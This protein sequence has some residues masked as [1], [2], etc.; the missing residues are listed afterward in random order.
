MV[1]EQA[2]KGRALTF[3]HAVVRSPEKAEDFAR[4]HDLVLLTDYDAA[5]SSVDV[6]VAVLATPHAMHVPQ[7]I[8]AAGARKHVFSEKPLALTAV[9]AG[10]AVAACRKAGVVLGLGTDRRLL[11]A[12]RRLSDLVAA[13]D[14]GSI[15]H[16]EGQY[17]NNNMRRGVSGGWRSDPELNP[18][19]G[20][21]GPG[22]HVLDALL[23]VAG[24]L[25][26]VVGQISR[27]EGPTAMVDAASA[28]LTFK[29]GVT[30]T[31]GVVRGVPDYFRVAVF[32]SEGW[33]ELTDFGTLTVHRNGHARF[34]EAH[35]PELAISALLDAF[36][37]AV[38]G[39]ADFPVSPDR[40]LDTVAAF[41][42]TVAAMES[43]T[44]IAV[45]HPRG[46]AA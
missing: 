30:G 27:P 31:L 25:S 37:D 29:S 36:G 34:S 21:T 35:A 11:P 17:S 10:R 40:M 20:M 8:A 1:E 19:A 14:L 5:L 32:G 2:A 28:L 26:N 24:P 9:E 13:G 23:A 22:L 43:G 42:A 4:R 16:V 45:T 41:E 6:D 33:A 46:V 44:R 18:G 3:T 7:V 39:R 38:E 12:M 15:L